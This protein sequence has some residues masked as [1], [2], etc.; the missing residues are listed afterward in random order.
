MIIFIDSSAYI[1][2]Y[3]KR[4]R[5][6]NKAVSLIKRIRDGELGP[7]I[8]YTS[9]YIFDEVLTTV[10]ILTKDKNLAVKVGESIKTSKIT[11]IVKIDEEIF[12]KA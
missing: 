3:N 11:K 2:Y 4:D 5:N 6:H 9:D 12:N 1:A 7:I 10:L 8:I